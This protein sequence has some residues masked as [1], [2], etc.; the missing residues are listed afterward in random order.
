MTTDSGSGGLGCDFKSR[1]TFSLFGFTVSRHGALQVHPSHVTVRVASFR[2]S[3]SETRDSAL[4]PT[5]RSETTATNK[6][7]AFQK[8]K[9][10]ANTRQLEGFQT[11]K[12]RKSPALRPTGPSPNLCIIWNAQAD[13]EMVPGGIAAAIIIVS[14]SIMIIK[15]L[16]IRLGCPGATVRVLRLLLAAS[17]SVSSTTGH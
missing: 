12:S 8:M 2:P 6:I 7:E 16:R 3:E 13:M 5:L 17:E 4:R 15:S 10:E 14:E 11:L 1:V 9:P